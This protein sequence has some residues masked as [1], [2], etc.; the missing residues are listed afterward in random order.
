M[1]IAKRILL[2]VGLNFLVILMMSIIFSV[3]GVQPYISEYGLN[4]ASLAIFCLLWGFAGSFISLFLSKHIAKWMYHLQMIDT[5]TADPGLREIAKMVGDLSRKAGLTKLPEVGIYD[6]EEI[7]AFA[8]G[9]SRSDSLVAVSTGL[10]RQMDKDEI[11]AVLG[12]EISHVANGDMVTMT[13]LQGVVNA[14]CMF[15]SRAIAFAVTLGRDDDS[16]MSGWLAYYITRILLEIVFMLLGSMLVS[17]YSR[18]REYRADAGGAQLAGK[19][20]MIRALQKLQ[21]QFENI[22]PKAD[23]YSTMMISNKPAGIIDRLFSTHPPLEARI[24]KLQDS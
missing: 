19:E 2:F 13:L 12:H 20:K 14:F 4:Y 16:A 15:L 17:A 18:H 22:K 8:T 6:S 3:L 23:S 5:N 1:G 9:P 7:N 24:K 21:A 10:L 11:E